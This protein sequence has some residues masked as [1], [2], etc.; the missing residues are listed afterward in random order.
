MQRQDDYQG[1]FTASPPPTPPF[2][3]WEPLV[4]GNMQGAAH[5]YVRARANSRAAKVAGVKPADGEL[6]ERRDAL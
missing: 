4:A 5:T 1:Y 2:P 3:T 6:A